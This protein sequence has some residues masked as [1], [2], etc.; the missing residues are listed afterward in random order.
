[1]STIDAGVSLDLPLDWR[2]LA[3]ATVV[4]IVTVV[5][6]GVAPASRRRG[7]H[8]SIRRKRTTEADIDADG[9]GP[10]TDWSWPRSRSRSCCSSR[11]IVGANRLTSCSR[12]IGV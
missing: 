6:F 1:M 4:T 8:R 9:E 3:F 5:L 7:E 12:S 2:V 10:Q 11:G